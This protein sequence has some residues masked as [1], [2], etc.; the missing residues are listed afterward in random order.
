MCRRKHGITEGIEG[1]PVYRPKNAFQVSPTIVGRAN[2]RCS[3]RLDFRHGVLTTSMRVGQVFSKTSTL[4]A[5]HFAAT[6]GVVAMSSR[7]PLANAQVK[8]LVS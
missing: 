5:L 1:Y 7:I 4:Y 8:M 3:Q 2:V 6:I